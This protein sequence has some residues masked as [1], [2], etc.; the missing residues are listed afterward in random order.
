M[1]DSRTTP[2]T[3]H[4]ERPKT[5]APE[6]SAL[7]ATLR[8]RIR[9]Y[10]WIEGIGLTL[11]TLG[12]GFWATLLIDWL[13][14]PIALVRV[15]LVVGSAVAAGVVAYRWI[16]AR[17]W[18]RLSDRSLALV[19]ER[20]FPA[21]RDSLL[22]TVELSGEEPSAEPFHPELLAATAASA[23]RQIAT[24]DLDDIFDAAPL[25]R[26]VS[27]ALLM[28]VTILIYGMVAPSELGVWARRNLLLSAELWP[29]RTHLSIE[30]FEGGTTKVARG[31][32]LRVVAR[33]DTQFEVPQVVQIRYRTADGARGWS[34][35]SREGEASPS[36]D[37]Y[38]LF[39]HKFQGI[40]SPLEFDVVGGD[41]RIRG[42]QVEVVESPT[43]T[44]MWLVC[45][46]PQYTGRPSRRLPVTGLMQ[47]P[48]G[49]HVTVEATANKPLV[50]V[51]LDE[52][53][54]EG[55][56][57]SRDVPLEAIGSS[58]FQLEL[59]PLEHDRSLLFSLHDTDDITSR[60]PLRLNLVA[61]PDVPPTLAVRLSGIGTAITPEARLPIQGEVSDDYGLERIW[62]EVQRDDEAPRQIPLQTTA[63]V[64][65]VEID[66]AFEVEGLELQ[67]GQRFV[68]ALQAVDRYA[69]A[70]EP[71]TGESERFSLEVV[72]PEE[73]RA[74]LEARELN[75]RRR[76]E[77]IIAE[78]TETRQ[79]LTELTLPQTPTAGPSDDEVEADEETIDPLEQLAIRIE[80]AKQNSEKNANETRGVGV[81]FQDIH[82]E[83]V[84]NRIDVEELKSRLKEGIADPLIKL[85]DFGFVELV[86]RLDAAETAL[87]DPQQA[88]PTLAA[89]VEQS[90]AILIEMQR[91]L[92]TMVELE[93]FNEVVA[94]LRAIVEEQEALNQQTEQRRRQKIRELLED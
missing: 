50:S 91:V 9:R 2:S 49:S 69:L 68:L 88:P 62:Y 72:T 60:E 39:A 79:S 75:L 12:I 70:D 80:R 24:I 40:L 20:R 32:D 28:A 63:G 57:S 13:F 59:G 42:L 21:F 84:N 53:D 10:V 35:M 78:V 89:A 66:T 15:L 11:A 34:N 92:D 74:R 7:L 73:L 3:P 56:V 81:S 29:R 47:L 94:L 25:T 30:G 90:D 52:P 51:S 61:T 43:L 41:D 6:I 77:Q 87:V 26:A 22:T 18:V 14:E 64:P 86:R 48:Q 44:Q 76:F 45:E 58:Q 54:A 82:A 1:T 65:R 23:Q 8:G 16:V 37:P 71:H 67:A 27:A 5:L 4:D 38:Q 36:A 46:F 33:A 31:T 17:S 55:N 83:L 19:I 93:T 85:A